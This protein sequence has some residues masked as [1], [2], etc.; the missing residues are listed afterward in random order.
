MATPIPTNRVRFS[1]GDILTATGGAL[2]GPLENAAL[3]VVGISTD[4]RSLGPGQ[5]FVALVGE[6]F[7]GHDRLADVA[8]RGAALAI[9]ERDVQVPGLTVLRVESTLAA[10]AGLADMRLTKWRERSHGRVLALTGSAG[11]TTTK[12]ALAAL[13][14][15]RLPGAVVATAGNLNN[16]VGVPMTMLAISDEARLLIL[17]M[18]TNAP[19]EIGKLARMAR[20][21]IGLVTLIASA[22]SEGLGGIEGIGREKTAM[23]RAL[24][25]AGIAIGNA[26]DARVAAGLRACAAEH[27]VGY[28]TSAS[29]DYR[30]VRREPIGID[31]ARLEV[32][33]E[34]GSRI[35]FVTPLVGSAG[36]LA[37]AA[38]LAAIEAAFPGRPFHDEE[39]EAALA[40]LA[41]D[42]VGPGR[43]APRRLAS[44]LVLV[45]D[46]Y[47]ANPASC[48]ASIEAAR[49]LAQAEGRGLVLVLG[50]M[51]ELGEDRESAHRALGDWAHR[52]Q[53]RLVL[54]V[55]EHTALSAER[56]SG[57]G[58]EV[59][60][61][62][63]PA[64]AAV[65]ARDLV[66]SNDL[67]LVKGSRG[68]RTELVVK[69]LLEH[70]EA[71]A[72]ASSGQGAHA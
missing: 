35:T 68:V 24:G 4:S 2:R 40:A 17:E 31:R 38:A 30:I 53:A 58:L 32:S 49:E 26:D 45:D 33:R 34:D 28:G 10:L 72:A 63:K 60:H 44:G 14:E 19:G 51:L 11:K 54:T 66:E 12:R 8:A 5:A 37:T 41:H 25:S 71:S 65:L 52:S 7:D 62:S 20:P 29:A 16:L 47:N 6:R 55:G 27:K 42:E 39:A 69:A 50:D 61:S 43:L 59:R 9:V 70:H 18:G 22:H 67:V 1:L 23:F 21:D 46:S 13:A 3:D 56:A 64:D 15:A 36:A 48:E 57:L